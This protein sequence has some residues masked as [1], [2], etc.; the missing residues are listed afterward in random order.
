LFHSFPLAK[1]ILK[2][3]SLMDLTEVTKFAARYA[4]AWCS[5]D[6]ET[7]AAFYAEHGSLSVN[8]G[9]PAVGRQAIANV[10][11]GF[12]SAFPDMKVTMDDLVRKPHEPYGTV[13]HWTL[14]GTNT[15]PGGT[16]KHVRISGYELWQ[17]DED[18]LIRDSKGHFDAAEYERQVLHGVVD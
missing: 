12:M 4:K 11:R 8:G 1:G 3:A 5:Q 7:V 14:T 9:P 18:G 17:L 6:P 16:G 10:A 2:E 13:F 15:G